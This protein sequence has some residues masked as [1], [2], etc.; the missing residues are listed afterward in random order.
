[1]LLQSIIIYVQQIL[2]GVTIVI[3]VSDQ[4]VSWRI[5]TVMMVSFEV[6]MIR[7]ENHVGLDPDGHNVGRMIRACITCMV[8]PVVTVVV[9][10]IYS[11]DLAKPERRA[12][13]AL[14]DEAARHAASDAKKAQAKAEASLAEAKA[15]AK[16]KKAL[17]AQAI[18]DYESQNR[19]M[20][21]YCDRRSSGASLRRTLNSLTFTAQLACK[22][23]K[24]IIDASSS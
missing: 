7:V 24:M 20:S 8:Y 6:A 22:V 1:M 5:I 13:A 4:R 15:T 21:G 19:A 9:Y 18:V 17:A 14:A 10:M 23:G 12:K 11:E 2:S 16:R 3:S